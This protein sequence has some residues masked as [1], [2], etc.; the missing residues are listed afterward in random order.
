M[1]LAGLTSYLALRG[2]LRTSIARIGAAAT[3]ATLPAVTGALSG[4]RLG[5]AVSI[6]LL[7]WLVRSAARL[8]GVGGTPTWRR[9]AGTSLLLAVVASF[10]PVVWIAATILAIVAAFTVVLD[11]GGR[12]RLLATVI[13]PV[14]LLVPWSLRVVREPALLWLEPGLVGPT[15]LRLTSYDVL[16]LRPGGVGSTPLWLG[17]GLLLAGLVALV[18][19]GRRRP[20]MAAWAVGLTGLALGLV[21]QVIRVTPSALP[22]PVAPWPGVATALWGGALIVCAAM[23]LERLPRRLAGASFGWRQPAA[24]LLALSVLIAP[25]ASIGHFL[26]GAD[27]PVHRGPREV[28]PAYVAAEM[29]DLGASPIARAQT[30]RRRAHHLRPAGCA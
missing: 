21:Q 22:E 23:T 9:A 27:G 15:D 11:R 13:A 19:P 28:L 5:T 6:V 30:W 29:P 20:A 3:Y 10:T 24:A 16:L 25:V 26:L 17:A 7:P 14:A 12:V 1:P 8:V 4:G 18:M 2:V